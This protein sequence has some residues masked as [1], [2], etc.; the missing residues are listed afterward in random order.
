MGTCVCVQ[1]GREYM[2]DRYTFEGRIAGEHTHIRTLTH[3]QRLFD[4]HPMLHVTFS[5]HE[6]IPACVC[7]FVHQAAMT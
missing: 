2:E 7:L 5:E 4:D 1:G 6:L 3:T